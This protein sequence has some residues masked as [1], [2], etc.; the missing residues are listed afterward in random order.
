ML[1]FR[2]LPNYVDGRFECPQI[3]ITNPFNGEVGYLAPFRWYSF[4]VSGTIDGE[5]DL[6]SSVP[7]RFLDVY[8]PLEDYLLVQMVHAL[9][10][11][12][13]NRYGWIGEKTVIT[14][15]GGVASFK[16][17]DNYLGRVPNYT[18]YT[19]YA[20][21]NEDWVEDFIKETVRCFRKYYNLENV[22]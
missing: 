22:G 9:N 10:A 2:R 3:E 6:G 5:W 21:E 7:R 11:Y 19:K 18:Q 17:G 14:I 12:L 8:Q 20:I 13:D 1:K 4:Q 16:L 15:N